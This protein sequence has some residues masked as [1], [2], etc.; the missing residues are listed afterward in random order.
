MQTWT[1]DPLTV[2][3]FIKLMQESAE[4]LTI[5]ELPAPRKELQKA[6]IDAAKE[7]IVLTIAHATNLRET[8]LVSDADVSATAHQLYTLSAFSV[9]VMMS[10]Y[11][12]EPSRRDITHDYPF[13]IDQAHSEEVIASYKKTKAFVVPI[14]IA[15]SPTMGL[16]TAKTCAGSTQAGKLLTDSSRHLLCD[17]MRTCLKHGA[18]SMHTIM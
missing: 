13:Q 11:R 9:V 15:I 14:F 6:V 12:R 16:G 7:H 1:N 2:C 17:Y 10:F 3:C 18:F 5:Q 8:L 4:G